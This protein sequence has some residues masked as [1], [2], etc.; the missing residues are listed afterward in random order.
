MTVFN[1]EL[2]AINLAEPIQKRLAR[3][4]KTRRHDM[5]SD[6][7]GYYRWTRDSR[8]EK[9][10]GF[11]DYQTKHGLTFVDLRIDDAND[12]LDGRLAQIIGYYIDDFEHETMKPVIARLPRSRGFLAGWSMGEGMLCSF[13]FGTHGTERDAAICAHSI[14]ENAAQREREYQHEESDQ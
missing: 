9:R 14:A 3:Y 7:C 2:L 12:H 11:S 5:A 1:R 13:D 4:K 6:H 10:D 8:A